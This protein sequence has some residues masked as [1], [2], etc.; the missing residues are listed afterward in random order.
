MA[1][2][3]LIRYPETGYNRLIINGGILFSTR[4]NKGPIIWDSERAKAKEKPKVLFCFMVIWCV[5]FFCFGLDIKIWA[6]SFLSPR[7]PE[8]CKAT[9][10]RG[11]YLLGFGDI[12]RTRIEAEPP[13]LNRNFMSFCILSSHFSCDHSVSAR[14]SNLWK[15]HLDKQ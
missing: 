14:H 11:G 10:E 5:L 13:H 8:S 9:N 4:S 7:A 1:N 12:S 3:G 6:G 15:S 2:L